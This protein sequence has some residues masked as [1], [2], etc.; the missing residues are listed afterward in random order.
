MA[1]SNAQDGAPEEKNMLYFV[2]FYAHGLFLSCERLNLGQAA[3]RWPKLSPLEAHLGLKR[4]APLGPKM[5][6][7][8]ETNRHHEQF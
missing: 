1:S 4:G 8:G 2:W 5:L 3:S 7:G 6:W